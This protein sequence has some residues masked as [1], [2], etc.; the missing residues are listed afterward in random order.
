MSVYIG[1]LDEAFQVLEEAQALYPDEPG[2]R[3]LRIATLTSEKRHDEAAAAIE[4]ALAEVEASEETAELRHRL[5]L[6]QAQVQ[7]LQGEKE[8]A[9]DALR[10]A[11]ASNPGDLAAWQLLVGGL[12]AAAQQEEA[13]RLLEANLQGDDPAL[14]LY[15]LLAPLYGA[16]GRHA[17]AEQALRSLAANSDAAAGI[18]P[19]V[20]Y[21][22]AR[23][24]LDELEAA[25]R[26]ATTRFP[27]EPQLHAMLV[28]ALL[29]MDSVD[30]AESEAAAYARLPGANAA[31]AEYFRAR[32][33]LA[34]G[35][36]AAAAERLRKLAP[37]LD[38]A[39]TQ[40]WLARALEESG[41]EEGAIR[42]YSMARLRDPRWPSPPVALLRIAGQRDDWRAVGR[43]AQEILS[44]APSNLD[45]W[46][47]MCQA[48]VEL[49]DGKSLLQASDRALEIFEQAPAF[50]IFRGHAL[51]LLGREA[52]AVEEMEKAAPGIEKDPRL[53][54][55]LARAWGLLGRLDQGMEVVRQAAAEHPDEAPLQSA[56]ATLSY[57]S[58]DTA[59]GDRAS[60]RALHLDP[61][62]PGPLLDRCRYRTSIGE[63]AQAIGDC[64][65]YIRVRPN[66]PGGF[67]LLG[68]AH[69]GAG[70][71]ALAIPAYAR[72]AELDELDFHARNNLAVLLAQQ[73]DLDGALAAGQEAYRLSEEN[74]YVADTLGDLYLRR[75][76]VDR[77][78]SLLESAHA[79]A[80]EMPD[81]ALHL[82]QA[83][84]RAGRGEEARTLLEALDGSMA[85]DHAL[86]PQLTE[87]L[88]ALP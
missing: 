33:E 21:L 8:P 74:P 56:M 67:F 53:A 44:I 19:L 18:V 79:A 46:Q 11:V 84:G 23:G 10:T 41:D 26:E 39:T 43:R 73:G 88:R 65:R 50:H 60:E 20:S 34:S 32:F 47:A 14:D 22:A 86:R 63:F 29:G 40:Y 3:M 37:T 25:V 82:A 66:N 49:E 58:G 5:E 2:S 64:E 13:I 83:Y 80:S 48:Y 16:S 45:G 54:A 12:M 87:A 77:A 35:D 28:E 15:I 75:G 69:E 6:M 52:E 85:P 30:A 24:E 4:E 71:P 57:A 61:E 36:A 72:A 55:E 38:L 17:E 78:I 42:R 70:A 7:L 76:L 31:Q 68:A 9:L 27:G 1:R 51:R 59:A 81:A 62:S